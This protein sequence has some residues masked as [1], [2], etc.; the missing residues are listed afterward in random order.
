MSYAD[1]SIHYLTKSSFWPSLIYIEKFFYPGGFKYFFIYVIQ[2]TINK[3]L[4]FICP[5]AIVLHRNG[6]LFFFYSRSNFS[7]LYS[8]LVVDTRTNIYNY[9]LLTNLLAFF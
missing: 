7:V 5:R 6:D 9:K 1:I 3:V 2:Q 8:F 4:K